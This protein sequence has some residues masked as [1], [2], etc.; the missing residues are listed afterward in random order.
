MNYNYD[1]SWYAPLPCKCGLEAQATVRVCLPNRLRIPLFCGV[2]APR[3]HRSRGRRQGAPCQ[4][5]TW[6]T[7]I[8]KTALCGSTEIYKEPV[9][10]REHILNSKWRRCLAFQSRRK[11][12]GEQAI[13]PDAPTKMS[14]EP[15]S[16]HATPRN[17]TA[18]PGI[19]RLL[20]VAGD[21]C[22]EALGRGK[23]GLRYAHP[24]PPF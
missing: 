22:S 3:N 18:G 20:C 23:L 4:S 14:E 17:S 21:E 11:R 1:P 12:M 19:L 13:H 5:I 16:L 2:K 7:T 9:L 15:L 10:S 6:S 8:Q 24:Q